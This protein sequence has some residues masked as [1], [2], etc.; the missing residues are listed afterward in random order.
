MFP[1]SAIGQVD[2]L[3]RSPISVA[4]LTQCAE[5][6]LRALEPTRIT[7]RG[8]DSIEF[9]A[10]FRWVDPCSDLDDFSRRWCTAPNNPSI[11]QRPTVARSGGRFYYFALRRYAVASES[12][13]SL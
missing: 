5:V 10:G 1:L 7:V 9:K 6:E 13:Y 8:D 11:G 3:S 12:A 2:I 4:Q